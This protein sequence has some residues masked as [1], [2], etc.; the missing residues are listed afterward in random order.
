MGLVRNLDKASRV[1]GSHIRETSQAR[2]GSS[3][4]VSEKTKSLGANFLV[5]SWCTITC[6][7]EHCGATESSVNY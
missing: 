6:K 1:A 7:C 3:T 4:G 2:L 5:H